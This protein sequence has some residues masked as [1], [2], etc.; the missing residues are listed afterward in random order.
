ME[1]LSG[2]M[3]IPEN[4]YLFEAFECDELKIFIEKELLPAGTGQIEFLIVS[5][6]YFVVEIIEKGDRKSVV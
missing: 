2:R 6:G 1:V 5:V 3:V 4:P